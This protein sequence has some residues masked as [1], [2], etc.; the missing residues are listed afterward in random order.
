MCGFN[1]STQHRPV[2]SAYPKEYSHATYVAAFVDATGFDWPGGM[3]W[4]GKGQK[5]R[6]LSGQ[7]GRFGQD[8]GETR[9]KKVA[10]NA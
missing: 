2:C 5:T 1:W 8:S 10:A 9:I 7:R 4:L 3:D 6:I